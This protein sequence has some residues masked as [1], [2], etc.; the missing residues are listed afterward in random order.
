MV[1]LGRGGPSVSRIGLGMAALGRPAYITTGRAADFG[2]DRSEEAFCRRS[3]EVLDAAY[4]AGIRYLDCARSYG[5]AEAFV[6][7]RL[8]RV[9]PGGVVGGPQWGYNPVGG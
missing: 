4:A 2:E 7:G 6:A 3:W 1:S 5:S 8:A 9:R